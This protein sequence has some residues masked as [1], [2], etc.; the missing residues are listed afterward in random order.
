MTEPRAA[1]EWIG[2]R[3]SKV[4]V[5]CGRAIFGGPGVWHG[6]LGDE[7]C[8]SGVSPTSFHEPS[9]P[10]AEVVAEGRRIAQEMGLTDAD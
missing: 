2:E 1:G 3:P 6:A 7:V 9:T 8:P 5:F 10:V 4:C